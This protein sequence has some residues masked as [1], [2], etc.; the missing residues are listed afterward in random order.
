MELYRENRDIATFCGILL[1]RE[2]RQRAMRMEIRNSDPLIL[3]VDLRPQ[4][5]LGAVAEIEIDQILIRHP[6]LPR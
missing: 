4:L 5:L 3:P 2:T 1:K 6:N